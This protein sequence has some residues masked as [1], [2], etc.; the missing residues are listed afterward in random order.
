MRR[1]PAGPG[2]AAI[3]AKRERLIWIKE[4]RDPTSIMRLNAL[5][6]AQSE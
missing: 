3:N 4:I 2:D 6:E 1:G 5:V